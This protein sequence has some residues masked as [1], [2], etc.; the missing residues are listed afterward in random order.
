M[1]ASAGVRFRLAHEPGSR[2][3]TV[4]GSSS[5]CSQRILKQALRPKSDPR[6][7]DWSSEMMLANR[8]VT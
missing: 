8:I 5:C 7:V 2:Q 1:A 4:T 3:S 6:A